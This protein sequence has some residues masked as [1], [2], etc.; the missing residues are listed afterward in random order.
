MIVCVMQ[1]D[2][3]THLSTQQY[4]Q[5]LDAYS[6]GRIR[7]LTTLPKEATV[8]TGSAAANLEQVIIQTNRGLFLLVNA[9]D[10]T[11][12]Q[13]WWG[14]DAPTYALQLMTDLKLVSAEPLATKHDEV[15]TVHRFDRRFSVFQL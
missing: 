5:V 6:V 8:G 11:I 3:I 9:I 2:S 4:Q 14:T 13:L 7:Q 1:K 15:F 10:E 12:H